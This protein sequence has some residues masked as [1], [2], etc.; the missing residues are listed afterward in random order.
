MNTRRTRGIAATTGLLLLLVITTP[1][2]S[3][4]GGWSPPFNLSEWHDDVPLFRL[5]LGGE[6]TQA[7]FWQAEQASIQ[8]SL[9]VRVRPPG[10]DWGPPES[11]TG[12]Q[13]PFAD[14]PP[15]PF[16]DA[17]VAPDGT[18]WAMWAAIDSGQMG[19]NV[20]VWA[21]SR[22]AGGSWHTEELTSGYET[23]VA[24]VDLHVGPDGDLAA[25][26]L[27]CTSDQTYQGP[28][29][30]RVRRRPAG[31]PNW[32][33]VEQP[34]QAVGAG[35]RQVSVLVGPGGLTVVL[36]KQAGPSTPYQEAI[37]ARAFEPASGTWDPGPTNVSGWK[38]WIG[39]AWVMDP[40]GTVTAA[41]NSPAADPSKLAIYAST[42]PA[43]SGAWSAPPAQ[44]SSAHSTGLYPP[45]LAVGP[46]GTVA[47]I[48][49]YYETATEYYVFA[50]ARDAGSTWGAEALLSGG[51]GWQV[52]YYNLRTAVWPDGTAMALYGIRDTHRPATEDERLHWVVR[53]P[54]GAWG[55][56]GQG[57]V[58]DW[59][60]HI[61]S[62]ALAATSDGRAVAVW[63][64]E[65]AGG[66][67]GEQYAVLAATWPPGG[68]FHPPVA[69]A[70]WYQETAP[71]PAGLIAGPEGHPVA[72][73]WLGQRASDGASAVFYNELFGGGPRIYLPMV[74]K[75]K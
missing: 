71:A 20:Q 12:P 68:P 41:W 2:L 16:W 8:W 55:D 18:A 26:W 48:W 27:A 53:P 34:D 45:S 22:P 11:F 21:S 13:A 57:E 42:R 61:E 39:M 35:I 10:G 58:G 40:A 75:G 23:F 5:A 59:V 17:G 72:A 29:H 49:A 25:A 19:D 4:A 31:A 15:V 7:A 47:A 63:G 52:V 70:Q 67:A 51:T 24:W 64:L 38:P 69:I 1:V 60:D 14:P 50:N 28:C 46:N 65:D 44:L 33:P 54:H 36:W 32:E 73:A 56:G 9:G 66:P 6:G 62:P 74:L 30:V 43:A 37:M 3:A